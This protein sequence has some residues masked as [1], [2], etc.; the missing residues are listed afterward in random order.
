MLVIM[1]THNRDNMVWKEGRYYVAQSLR[2]DVSSFGLTRREALANLNEALELYVE[3][4]AKYFPRGS[5]W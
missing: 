5:A 4:R 1:D 3:P 2:A